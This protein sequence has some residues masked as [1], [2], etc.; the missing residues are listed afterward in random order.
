MARCGFLVKPSEHT[1]KDITNIILKERL[2]LPLPPLIH[3]L[4]S[5]LTILLPWLYHASCLT[6][7]KE[8]QA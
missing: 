5:P 6:S 7:Q 4:S 3:V 8:K 2:D 1:M